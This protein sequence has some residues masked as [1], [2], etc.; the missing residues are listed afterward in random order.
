M[1]GATTCFDL[2]VGHPGMAAILAQQVGL[3]AQG[4]QA[5]TKDI[6]DNLR[7]HAGPHHSLRR[8]VPSKRLCE[9]DVDTYITK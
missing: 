4:V 9:R 6:D 3:A 1:R 2:E 5:L 7:A 8:D